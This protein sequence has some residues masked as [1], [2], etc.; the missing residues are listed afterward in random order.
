MSSHQFSSQLHIQL[1]CIEQCRPTAACTYSTVG[2]YWAM[3]MKGGFTSSL[4]AEY[5]RLI[6][7][8]KYVCLLLYL[9]LQL[10]S[11][12]LNN[13]ITLLSSPSPPPP[14]PPPL[15]LLPLLLLLLPSFPGT[16]YTR[17]D[18][19]GVLGW[20]SRGQVVCRQC[21]HENGRPPEH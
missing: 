4:G 11:F 17:W 21:L 18:N 19:P 9:P 16:E 12:I 2:M 3:R 14:P 10:P 8:A 7:L 6:V 20:G 1:V 5:G 13:Y 15:P